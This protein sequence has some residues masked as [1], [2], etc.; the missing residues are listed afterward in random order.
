MNVDKHVE[1]DHQE[2]DVPVEREEVLKG[3]AIEKGSPDVLSKTLRPI[4]GNNV[5]DSFD[6]ASW[7]IYYSG[8]VAELESFRR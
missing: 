2:F 8:M 6:V 7:T 4:L 1:T 5:D 3:N